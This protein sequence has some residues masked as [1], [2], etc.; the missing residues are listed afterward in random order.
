MGLL[1]LLACPKCT[2]AGVLRLDE[3]SLVCGGCKRRYPIVDGI[4]IMLD[5]PERARVQ[6]QGVL[7]ARPDYSRWK[8]RI[9]LRS[10]T[11]AQLALDFGAGRQRATI[12]ASS[13]WI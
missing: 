2:D 6:H 9:V 11:D 3:S 13:G 7:P 1:E 10:L 5:D 8:E 12:P 4:P